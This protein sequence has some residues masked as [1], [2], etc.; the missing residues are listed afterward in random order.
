MSFSVF[1]LI[2]LVMPTSGVEFPD[3]PTIAL[4]GPSL[5]WFF[6]LSAAL[7]G[8]GC[9]H[10]K[11]NLSNDKGLMFF[12]YWEIALRFVVQDSFT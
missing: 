12:F 6:A 7:A 8:V 9:K 3:L 2:K 11:I 10:L 1:S 4:M 5:L